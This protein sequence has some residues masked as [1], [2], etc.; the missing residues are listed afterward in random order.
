M[1]GP[2]LRKVESHHAIHDTAWREADEAFRMAVKAHG[3]D[4]GERF[5]RVAEVF[6]QVMEGRILVHAAEE[7]QG[8]Y[9][10]WLTVD[11]TLQPTIDE[12]IHEHGTIRQGSSELERAMIRG[13]YDEAVSVMHQLLDMSARH[14]RHEENVLRL[15][16]VKRSETR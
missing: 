6:L 9:H 14:S 4:N 12:L 11:T 8:L 13:E 16:S 7:E 15:L 2:A 5:A 1:S 3:S 10:E